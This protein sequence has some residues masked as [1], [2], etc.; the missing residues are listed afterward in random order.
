MTS[1]VTS[2][3]ASV[4]GCVGG[5]RRRRVRSGVC[6]EAGGR[7]EGR[8]HHEGWDG[9]VGLEHDDAAFVLLAAGARVRRQEWVRSGRLG[10]GRVCVA[11]GEWGRT[12]A[13]SRP[14]GVD[15]LRQVLCWS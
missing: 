15:T 2:H 4:R 5:E 11:H 6:G 13:G 10:R 9:R 3:C 7:K 12:G 1:Q 14:V 8:A